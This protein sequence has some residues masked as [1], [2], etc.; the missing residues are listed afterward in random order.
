VR[1]ALGRTFTV[2]DDRT[3]GGTEGP[4]AVI[5]DEFWRTHFGRATDVIGKPLA[6]GTATF[7][8]IG[9]TPE[10]FFGPDVGRRFDIVVPIA[11]EQVL[12]GAN[13]RV[14]RVVR[15][16]A[17]LTAIGIACGAMLSMWAVRFVDTLVWGLE[18]RDPATFL[19]AAATLSAVTAL[20]ATLPAW[21]ATRTDPASVLKET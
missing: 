14:V 3:G 5:S 20:A 15:P 16:V 11:T 9:V 18:P 4:A 19:T 13:A 21:S 1:A 8:I 7:T 6:L 17:A 12:S 10:G 2:E